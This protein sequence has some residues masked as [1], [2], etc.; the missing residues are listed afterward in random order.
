MATIV[1]PVA[2]AA[3]IAKLD[4]SAVPVESRE[5]VVTLSTARLLSYQLSLP[6]EA[7][8]PYG[9]FNANFKTDIEKAAALVNES[10]VININDVVELTRRVWV[11]RYRMAYEPS[12]ASVTQLID[13]LLRI[14][15]P[16]VDSQ[17][18][19]NFNQYGDHVAKMDL[20]MRPLVL[21]LAGR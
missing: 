20:I 10:V 17:V 5:A 13:N 12:H 9:Y 21:S 4:L 11:F 16:E 3:A 15:C 18:I 14:G 19:A 8:E 7:V 6:S 1:S 2:L